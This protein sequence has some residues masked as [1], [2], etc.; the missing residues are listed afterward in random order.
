MVFPFKREPECGL[1]IVS[2][3]IDHKYELKMALDTGAT[4]TTLET[5]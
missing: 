3:E 1:I 5:T 4:N 2:I